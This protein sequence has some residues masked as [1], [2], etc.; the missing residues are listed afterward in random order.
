MIAPYSE[1]YRRS[2]S[3]RKIR[4]ISSYSDYTLQT[5]KALKVLVAALFDNLEAT[6][7]SKEDKEQEEADNISKQESK[8]ES[9]VSHEDTVQ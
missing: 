7:K 6:P 9:A 5:R 8:N 2:L 1:E 3:D 4:G